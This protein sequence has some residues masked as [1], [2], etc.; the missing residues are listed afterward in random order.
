MGRGGG[1]AV[2]GSALEGG[3]WPAPHPDCFTPEKES[4]YPLYRRLSGVW[5]RA[6][7]VRKI[8]PTLGFESRSIQPVARG[9]TD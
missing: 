9:Y 4:R 2:L 5:D 8:S 7:R 3:G 1:I 6:G